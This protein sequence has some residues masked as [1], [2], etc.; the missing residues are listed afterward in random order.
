MSFLLIYNLQIALLTIFHNALF[1]FSVN[2][3]GINRPFN[4]AL[5]RF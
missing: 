4:D 2:N 1:Y 5:Q 3:F